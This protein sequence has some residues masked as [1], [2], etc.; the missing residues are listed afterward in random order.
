MRRHMFIPL[1][2]TLWALWLIP[3]YSLAQ[4]PSP[5]QAAETLRTALLQAQLTLPSEPVE[6]QRQVAE[7]RDTYIRLLAAP[8]TKAAPET[9]RRIE[10]G[11]AAAETALE[12]QDAPALAVARAQIWTGLLA[13]SYQVVESALQQGQDQTAREWLPLRE[14]RQATRFSRPN[15]DATLAVKGAISGQV[16]PADA[17]LVVRADLLDTYQAR[18]NEA[19]NDLED[20]DAHSFAVRRAE[21]AALAEGYFAIL[22]VAYREQRGAAALTEAQ[23]SLADLR[24]AAYTGRDLAA[25]LQPV[26]AALHNFRAAPLSPKEQ[27]RRAGQLL[28]YLSLVPVLVLL[29]K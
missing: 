18:L 15:A 20:A 13:G 6:A 27:A 7:A 28:R 10:A 3:G 22:S 16:T 5:A 8:L 24:A 21:H 2:L 14:F 26:E 23:Q 1:L 4:N 29:A 12:T 25:A 19:L 17:V 9:H 11:F